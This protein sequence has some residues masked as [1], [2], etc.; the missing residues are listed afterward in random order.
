MRA[1][2]NVLEPRDIITGGRGIS[3][4]FPQAIDVSVKLPD[5]FIPGLTGEHGA[6]FYCIH[7]CVAAAVTGALYGRSVVTKEPLPELR[8]EGLELL[9]LQSAYLR[10]LAKQLPSDQH[11]RAFA[12]ERARQVTAANH[13]AASAQLCQTT[14]GTNF[15][16][17]SAFLVRPHEFVRGLWDDRTILALAIMLASGLPAAPFHV[18]AKPD[19]EERKKALRETLERVRRSTSGPT[20]E[21][22][23][24]AI[25]SAS[26][27]ATSCLT[28]EHGKALIPAV[29]VGA[30]VVMLAATGV[31][32]AVAAPAGLA[33]AALI[34]STLAAFGPGG[35]IG[36]MATLA[37]LAG[38]GSAMTAAGTAI[39]VTS[40]GHP[41]PNLMA[42]ALAEVMASDNPDQLRA[43]LIS[44]LTL[45]DAQEALQF[46][47]QR[48]M[49]LYAC[50]ES[51]ARLAVQVHQHANIDPK[52]P[53]A[54]ATRTMMETLRK[55]TA[56]L[57]GEGGRNEPGGTASTGEKR[58]LAQFSSAFERAFGGDPA[59]LEAVAA[60][61]ELLPP[62]SPGGQ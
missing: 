10:E 44:L 6:N 27:R 26:R 20:D 5:A 14:A 42:T 35:M 29:L 36:G 7:P 11:D 18:E 41:T 15:F 61:P 32:L 47:S 46:P 2:V 1:W 53:A 60:R 19:T 34:T 22:M 52:S 28:T 40:P 50:E 58:Q 62:A 23:V 43:L 17:P 37:A 12:F 31:G 54:K 4:H 48:S 45:V 16:P 51:E 3:S 56:C 30:G 21:Q 33:G 24:E 9:L 8:P 39:G 55:A 49:T 38:V 59:V 57:R 25:F 13:S